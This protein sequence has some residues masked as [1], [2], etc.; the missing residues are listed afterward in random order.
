MNS[1]SIFQDFVYY[2]GGVY[3][4]VWGEAEGGHAVKLVGWG[5]TENGT[6]YWVSRVIHYLFIFLLEMK[7]EMD[8]RWMCLAL[9]LY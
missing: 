2:T 9:T 6:D 4:H 8:E 7:M 5:T 3:R 1:W